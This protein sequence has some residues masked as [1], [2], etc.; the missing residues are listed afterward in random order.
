MALKLAF[1]GPPSLPA[2]LYMVGP[3]TFPPKSE[4]FLFWGWWRCLKVALQVCAAENVCSYLRSV[5]L[6]KSLSAGFPP[7]HKM[8]KLYLYFP[9][10]YSMSIVIKLH[11]VS[12]SGFPPCIG[13]QSLEKF[14]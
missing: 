13:T 5:K 9:T 10:Q 11:S 6:L 3:L 8:L 12:L 2:I 14:L 1:I 4:L 7:V